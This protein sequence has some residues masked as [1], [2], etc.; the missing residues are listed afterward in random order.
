MAAMNVVAATKRYVADPRA[1]VRLFDA[2][3]AEVRRVLE[4]LKADTSI[5]VQAP[6]SEDEF[7]RRIA[8]YDKLFADLCRVQA[9]LGRWVNAGDCE[10][11]TLAPKRV[12][13]SL[14]AGGGNTTWLATQWYPALQ[15]LYAGGIA[16]V[17][18]NRYDVLREL[19]HARVYDDHRDSPV[20]VA[21]HRRL[22]NARLF[23]LLT[24]L[25]RHFVPRSEHLH[26]WLKP[27]LDETLLLG[28]DYEW[29]FDRFEVLSA[30]ELMYLTQRSA[31]IGRFGWKA[32]DIETSPLH[33][34]MN[35]AKQL[36]GDWAPLRVGFCGGS[37]ENFNASAQRIAA[38]LAQSPMIG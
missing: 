26:D 15:L 24:G 19:T 4:V 8:E 31:P 23:N 33:G 21:T 14:Q 7:R 35:E 9:L 1:R 36:A 12:C 34:V 5:S 28:A 32:G 2:V 22:N 17:A 18:A 27:L 38:V 37:L 20:V 13:D 30:V 11:L 25:E 16:A 10:T 6:W 29:A 3:G